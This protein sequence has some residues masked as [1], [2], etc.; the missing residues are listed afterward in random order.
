MKILLDECLPRKLKYDIT[1]HEVSTVTEMG[2]SSIRN[3]RLL[4]L[5]E[6]L[7]AVLLTVDRNMEHQQHITGRKLALGVFIS[8][9]N[10]RETLRL[11]VPDL[12][13]ALETVQPGEVFHITR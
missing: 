1:G 3:G 6:P 5:T 10:K 11:L 4:D 13:K 2:W 8:P 7:F 9:N 12:L